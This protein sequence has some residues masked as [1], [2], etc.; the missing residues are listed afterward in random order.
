M[1]TNIAS[2]FH[3]LFEDRSSLKS[4][5]VHHLE[6]KIILW[7]SPKM[8][9]NWDIITKLRLYYNHSLVVGDNTGLRSR[10]LIRDLTVEITLSTDGTT[11]FAKKYLIASIHLE[12]FYETRESF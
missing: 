7:T 10:T 6:R 9:K 8:D 3:K 11:V 4:S 2:V 12:R 5:S 1:R